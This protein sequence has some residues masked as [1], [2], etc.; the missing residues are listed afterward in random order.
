M[1]IWN[2]LRGTIMKLLNLRDARALGCDMTPAMAEA[3]RQWDELF[4]LT[5]QPLHSLKMAATLTSLMAVSYTHLTLPT[6]SLV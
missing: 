6:N 3:V 1:N 5:D 4:Y 2:T